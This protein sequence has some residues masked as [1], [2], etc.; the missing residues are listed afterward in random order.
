MSSF[1]SVRF[2]S[3]VAFAALAFTL[4][5]ERQASA[6]VLLAQSGAGKTAIGWILTLLA[7][8]LGLI[9]VLRPNKRKLKEKK[10]APPPQK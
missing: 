7:I 10:K 3:S 9:V 5:T 2:W 1:Y 8:T 6:Q 4:A